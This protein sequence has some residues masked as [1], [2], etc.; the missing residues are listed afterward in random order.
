MSDNILL[1]LYKSSQTVFLVKELSLRFTTIPYKNL[2]SRLHYLAKTGKLRHIRR[3]AYVK[4][5]YDPLELANKLYTPSYISFE[6]VLGKAGMVFQQYDTIFVASYLS[7]KVRLE[8]KDFYYRKLTDAVLLNSKG[9]EQNE[10]YAI[11]TPERAFLD[12]VFLY[13]SYHFDNL[14]PLNWEKVY[15]LLPLYDSKALKIRIEKYHSNYK[16]DYAK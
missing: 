6:T 2:K 3:G 1:S 13:K 8:N 15:E 7:R 12:A 4:D 14:S 9:I 16:H 11:A 10:S 5:P